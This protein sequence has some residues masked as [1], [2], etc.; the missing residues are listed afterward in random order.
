MFCNQ[1][2]QKNPDNLIFCSNC[3]ARLPI[4][5]MRPVQPVYEQT[6]VP[7]QPV[8]EHPM[9]QTLQ[10]PKKNGGLKWLVFLVIL[11]VVAAICIGV[12]IFIGKG[13]DDEEEDRNQ[14]VESTEESEE[15]IVEVPENHEAERTVMVYMIGSNLE[16]ESGLGSQDIGEMLL[17]ESSEDFKIVVQ[18]GGSSKWHN[19][20]IK[21]GRV[22]RF[23]IR[24]NRLV[25]LE[26][27]GKVSMVE[28]STLTDFISFAKEKYP[29][30]E[31]VL[32]M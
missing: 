26:D 25:E 27:L 21:G 22:Q 30:R 7:R 11:V 9:R 24:D 19:S 32:V 6:P 31:Y 20:K 4:P 12:G 23:E 3:G 29:A 13:N 18:T 17:A 16:A 5:V 15:N 10:E 1:C 8:Y 28:T 2:G 14:Y